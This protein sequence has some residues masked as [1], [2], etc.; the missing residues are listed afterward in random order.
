LQLH[1]EFQPGNTRQLSEWEREILGKNEFFHDPFHQLIPPARGP[2]VQTIH[3]AHTI[4]PKWESVIG[5]VRI[6]VDRSEA[7]ADLV[8]EEFISP[9]VV[10]HFIGGINL[11]P[12]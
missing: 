2:Q 7:W 6:K 8:P 5:M 12:K 1:L 10:S 4:P 11:L 9:S 3:L